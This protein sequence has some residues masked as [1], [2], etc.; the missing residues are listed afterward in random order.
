MSPAGEPAEQFHFTPETYLEMI[1]SDVPRYDEL[2]EAPS[3]RSR[4]RPAGCSSSASV[5]ARRPGGSSNAFPDAQVTGLDSTPE[6]VFRAREL[7]IDVRLARMEDPLPDGPWDLVIGVLVVHHLGA[8]GK[9]DLFRRVR[10]E[11]RALLIGDVVEVEPERRIASLTEGFDFPSPAGEQAEWCDG[12]VVW[13]ADDLA[14]IRAGYPERRSTKDQAVTPRRRA[15]VTGAARG[16]G[17]AAAERLRRDGLEVVTADRDEGCDLRFD[18]ASGELPELG[19]I[20]VCVSNAAVTDTIAPAHR[21]TAEQWNLDIAVNL[22]GAFRVIQACL[23]GMRERRLREDRRRLLERRDGRPPGPGRLRR[24]EGGP[25][26]DD[27]DDR[28]RERAAGDH[29]ERRPPR[30][31]RLGAGQVDAGGALRAAP[32]DLP[33][34]RP[35]GRGR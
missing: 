35:D 26:R 19:E 16:I 8:E 10:Q 27:E 28:R 24:L 29:R 6:M 11:S 30:A 2:Q 32:V 14:V 31:D 9:R 22:T 17:A 1:R 4:L 23:P 7:G 3:R 34:L 12:E 15:L 18:V 5:P 21:M 33:A 13:E 20:D 25:A